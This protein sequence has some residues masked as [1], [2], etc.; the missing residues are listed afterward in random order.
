MRDCRTRHQPH[1]RYGACAVDSNRTPLTLANFP[2]TDEGDVYDEKLIHP[3][4]L[5][6]SRLL[7][8]K[9]RKYVKDTI[10]TKNSVITTLPEIRVTKP[11]K[12]HP[13]TDEFAPPYA[14]GKYQ[15]K[16]TSTPMEPLETVSGRI[17]ERWGTDRKRGCA[18]DADLSNHCV[19]LPGRWRRPYVQILWY[20]TFF[21]LP[22][23]PFYVL[24]ILLIIVLN[25]LLEL[26][27]LKYF[28]FLVLWNIGNQK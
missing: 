5:K 27:I 22:I 20:K 25:I 23:C 11:E 8:G 9:P 4:A 10:F 28:N 2:G 1:H 6:L 3:L 14:N 17:R 13:K 19:Q 21:Y 15:K 12:T 7:P 18:P 16:A 26:P 24:C